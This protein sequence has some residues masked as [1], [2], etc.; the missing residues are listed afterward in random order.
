MNVSPK[1]KKHPYS[2]ITKQSFPVTGETVVVCVKCGDILETI[3]DDSS[4]VKPPEN[5]LGT[6]ESVYNYPD[7]T[8]FDY[9]LL[10]PNPTGTYGFG[11]M[12]TCPKCKG[13]GCYNYRFVE[14][15]N[16]TKKYSTCNCNQCNG[17]GYVKKDSKDESCVHELKEISQLECS[18]RK[19]NHFGMCYHVYECIKC[20]DIKSVDS[21]G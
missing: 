12:V 20:G 5:E 4:V 15:M 21:S 19:I 6:V 1:C 8:N 3:D 11:V 2:R 18:K 9:L 17:W 10:K 14:G 16:Y 7:G 13:H